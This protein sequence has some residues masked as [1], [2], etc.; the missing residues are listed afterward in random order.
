MKKVNE[1]IYKLYNK[2]VRIKLYKNKRS[3]NISLRFNPVDNTLKLITPSRISQ[4]R[5]IT[6][7]EKSELWIIK[8]ISK[9]KTYKEFDKEKI[10]SI[11]DEKYKIKHE[12]IIKPKSVEIK[13]NLI[14]IYSVESEVQNNLINFLK[15]YAKIELEKYCQK[16]QQIINVKYRKITIKDTK[17]QWGSC[18]SRGNISLCWRLVLAPKYVAEYVC[19]HEIAHLVEMN[20][21]KKFWDIVNFI[22]PN[23]KHAR[24]WLNKNGVSLFSYI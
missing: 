11:L 5:I 1:F 23:Q 15:E 19:A 2:E 12:N 20:H 3:K 22:Y 8:Q 7:L 17:S 16:Y 9:L 18:S 13:N 4:K 10:I 21:S 24:K 14:M 6:F